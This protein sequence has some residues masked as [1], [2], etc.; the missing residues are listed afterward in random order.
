M[1]LWP[2]CILLPIWGKTPTRQWDYWWTH[3]PPTDVAESLYPSIADSVLQGKAGETG[4]DDL[5]GWILDSSKL[6]R[7]TTGLKAVQWEGAFLWLA[8]DPGTWIVH[9]LG[10]WVFALPQDCRWAAR[11][12]AVP[13]P[14]GLN[15]P[16]LAQP[17]RQRPFS[18]TWPDPVGESDAS[19]RTGVCMTWGRGQAPNRWA[20]EEGLRTQGS[21]CWSS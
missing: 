6:T 21:R 17:L 5:L 19:T 10:A 14:S 13:C 11:A 18:R 2:E 16:A 20:W 12:C 15:A 7:G 4:S 9:Q 3:H 1:V 8:L